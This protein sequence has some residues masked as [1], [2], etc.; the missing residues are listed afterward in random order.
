MRKREKRKK[1]S[2]ATVLDRECLK[3]WKRSDQFVHNNVVQN[4]G[5]EIQ[6]CEIRK[7]TNELQIC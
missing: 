4:N 7:G 2:V 3:K 1:I 6:G 5:I